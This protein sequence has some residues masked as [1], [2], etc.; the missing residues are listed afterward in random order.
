MS[1][2]GKVTIELTADQAEAIV[3]R[4]K[5]GKTSSWAYWADAVSIVRIALAE[6]RRKQERE[7]LGLPW[8]VVISGRA[9]EVRWVKDG[10]GIEITRGRMTDAQARLM[11]AAPELAE[12]LKQL[13]KHVDGGATLPMGC[14]VAVNAYTALK[15]AGW[16]SKPSQEEPKAGHYR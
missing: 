5:R 8:G 3:S 4:H 14:D 2:D 9:N 10:S 7:A 6:H 13:L 15:K 1:D 12:A 16:T 11:A